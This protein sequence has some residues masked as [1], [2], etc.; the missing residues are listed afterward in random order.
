MQ[1]VIDWEFKY[2]IFLLRYLRFN[3][4]VE[5]VVK[6]V[7]SLF[8]KVFKDNIDFWFVFFDYYNIFIEGMK[9]SFIQC[10]ML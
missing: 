10:F 6:I 9:L 8:K 4:K 2:V 3:G 5:F 1:F 7:K